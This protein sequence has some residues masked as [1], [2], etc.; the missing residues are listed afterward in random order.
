MQAWEVLQEF[1]TWQAALCEHC[2]QSLAIV[3][4]CGGYLVSTGTSMIFT[5]YLCYVMCGVSHDDTHYWPV[6]SYQT[7]PRKGAYVRIAIN[8]RL[9]TLKA[10][11]EQF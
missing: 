2:L 6:R 4:M 1:L 7:D 10:D 5:Y 9:V 3:E 8:S 11:G